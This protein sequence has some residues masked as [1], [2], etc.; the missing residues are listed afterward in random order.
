M[1][2]AYLIMAHDAPEQLD[3]LL[4]R[5]VPEASDDL[6]IIHADKWSTLW[7]ELKTRWPVDPPRIRLIRNPVKV[8][9]GHWSMVAAI[10]RL[11]NMAVSER[12]DY[13]HLL[14]GSDWP[15]ASLRDFQTDVDVHDSP[16]C[17]ITAN[18]GDDSHRM[19]T[20][21]LDDR[22]FALK[23]RRFRTACSLL[24]RISV[25]LD[26]LRAMLGLNRSQPWG[27]WRKGATWWTLPADALVLL[28]VELRRILASGRLKGTLCCDE[29]VI[30]TII[31]AHFT[32]R[33]VPFR[34]FIDW[35]KKA[36]NPKL[37]TAADQP[38]IEASDAYFFRKVALANDPFF[39]AMP[40]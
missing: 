39:I 28:N 26:R 17:F 21:R 1:R 25:R 8:Y 23:D 2:V 18:A 29:H 4:E 40:V 15:A 34:R 27:E 16:P 22:W 3:L 7:R 9:W 6:A 11:I 32:D 24:H 14:S 12:C 37:L 35:S 33:M 13:A 5:L 10:A 38:A 20:Y 31:A 36:A 30:Q 19:E